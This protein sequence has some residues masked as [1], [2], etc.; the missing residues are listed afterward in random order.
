MKDLLL[1]IIKEGN[2]K[3]FSTWLGL[4]FVFG[5]ALSGWLIE[6]LSSELSQTKRQLQECKTEAFSPDSI[7]VGSAVDWQGERP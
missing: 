5:L 4:F 3:V 7:G 1:Q 2:K 6:R